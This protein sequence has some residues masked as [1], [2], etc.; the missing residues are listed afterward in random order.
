MLMCTDDADTE[1]YPHPE[2][3]SPAEIAQVY[4]HDRD[5]DQGIDGRRASTLSL[6]F[7]C[8]CLRSWFGR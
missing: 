1:I 3:P 6:H 7:D 8:A 4:N 5:D 2:K